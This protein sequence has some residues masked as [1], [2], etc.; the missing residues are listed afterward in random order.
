MSV[1]SQSTCVCLRDSQVLGDVS[2]LPG[3]HRI[4]CMLYDGRH[5]QLVTGSTSLE[6]I[7]RVTRAPLQTDHH[8]PTTNDHLPVTVVRQTIYTAIV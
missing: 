7:P 6:V 1:G 4:D 8:L 5:E 3:D 2:A